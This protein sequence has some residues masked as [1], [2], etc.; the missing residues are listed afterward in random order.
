MTIDLSTVE[1]ENDF[2]TIWLEDGS[3]LVLN[4]IDESI[5]TGDTT[6][7]IK[8][9]NIEKITYDDDGNEIHTKCISVIGMSDSNI[10]INTVYNEYLG[11]VL[12]SDNMLYC[13]IEV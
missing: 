8:A 1:F 11:K 13:T 5:L 4:N 9:I 12:N 10:S 7:E 2:C 3:S 6:V